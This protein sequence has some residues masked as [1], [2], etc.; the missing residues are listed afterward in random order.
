MRLVRRQRTAGE[1]HEGL[2]AEQLDEPGPVELAGTAD[3]EPWCPRAVAPFEHRRM[4]ARSPS[5][6]RSD[7]LP[8]NAGSAAVPGNDLCG[9]AW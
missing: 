3:V 4:M 7:S 5:D 1:G 8:R 6:S 2:I 9:S